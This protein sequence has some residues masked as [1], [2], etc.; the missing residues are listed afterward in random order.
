MARIPNQDR[1]PLHPIERAAVEFDAGS[2]GALIELADATGNRGLRAVALEMARHG[3]AH[4]RRVET[5]GR[6]G[7]QGAPTSRAVRAR[8]ELDA[9]F[10][11]PARG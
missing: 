11:P 3:R 5:W 9:L 6:I 10:A 8:A 2:L 7:R 1:A 4:R